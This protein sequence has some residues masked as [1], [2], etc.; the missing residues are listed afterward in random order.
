MKFNSWSIA[1]L[2]ALA[3]ILTAAAYTNRD[4]YRL[5][6]SEPLAPTTFTHPLGTDEMG[7]DLLARF[8]AGTGYTFRAGLVTAL[9]AAALGWLSALAASRVA[10]L[11]RLVVL[12]AHAGFVFPKPLLASTRAG[13]GLVAV[14]CGLLLLPLLWFGLA[15]I[16]VENPASNSLVLGPLFAIAAAFIM[17]RDD[18]ARTQLNALI[19]LLPWLIVWSV[20][21]HTAID[22]LG[23]G[24]RPPVPSWGTLLWV[25][26]GSLLPNLVVGLCLLTLLFISLA[27]S[28]DKTKS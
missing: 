26:S 20:Y 3:V 18:P 6:F 11:G 10:A 19:L 23:L 13:R 8:I 15:I 24:I 28:T 22:A 7:R 21:A 25:K 9:L 4:P 27:L 12:L 16:A 5:N 2:F 1:A 14:L 17:H